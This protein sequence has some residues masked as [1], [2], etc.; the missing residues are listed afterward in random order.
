MSLRIISIKI[1]PLKRLPMWFP[2]ENQFYQNKNR[3]DSSILHPKKGY[4]QK[5]ISNNIICWRISQ[6]SKT[7]H[8]NWLRGMFSVKWGEDLRLPITNSRWHLPFSL[9]CQVKCW[10]QIWHGLVKDIFIMNYFH[11]KFISQ[12]RFKCFISKNSN[13]RCNLFL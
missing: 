3:L 11:E 8:H 2:V 7:T 4:N 9:P 5:C 10:Y 12:S 6:L 1:Y 13:V